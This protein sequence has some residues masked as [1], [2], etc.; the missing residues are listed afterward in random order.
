MTDVRATYLRFPE[1][2][3][4]FWTWQTG[5]AL[6]GQQPL[7]RHTWASYLAVTLALFLSGLAVSVVSI[8]V[9]FPFWYLALLAG[10]LLT[11]TGERMMVLVIAH[12]AVHKRFS[13]QAAADQF[14][15]ELVLVLSVQNTFAE[16]REEHF[17]SHH[18]RDIFA[19]E[20]DPPAQF[21]LGLGF[22]P[23][24]SRAAMWRRAW[25]VLLS[26]AFYA[27]GFYDRV[28]GNFRSGVG[29]ATGFTLWAA[30]WLSL[31][32]WFPHG[33]LVLI[34]GFVLPVICF[35]TLSSLLDRLGEH[36][37]LARSPDQGARFYTA[38]VTAARY[39]GAPVPAR[40]VPVGPRLLA[41]IRWTALTVCYHL[42][43]RLLVVVGD[44]PNHD[45][46]HRY[47]STREWTTA[48]Y[49]RQRDID[50][51]P[52]GP[53]Y[54]EVWGIASAIDNLFRNWENLEGTPADAGPVAL[55]R[56]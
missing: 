40:S 14:W 8:G 38:S 46:H 7:L 16:L 4:H 1:W 53:A 21:L 50:N 30:L 54:H 26:P 39:C 11:A 33:L 22:R 12:Q 29:R 47:P 36:V 19:T 52:E 10:W 41:W 42:P 5:K 2:T 20:A 25:V 9:M 15:G 44:L 18:R 3:Q 6:P 31:P 32:F 27:R 28:R 35:A 24:R 34:G 48:A 43:A 37:W 55:S 17:D 56:S 13:G 51:G 49:A 45:Y 23:G